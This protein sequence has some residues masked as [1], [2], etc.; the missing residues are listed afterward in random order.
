MSDGPRIPLEKAKAVAR[1]LAEKWSMTEET[2]CLVVGSVR[3]ERKDCGDLDF[4]APLPPDEDHDALYDAIGTSMGLFTNKK[5]LFG[6]SATPGCVK[7]TVVKGFN[8]MFKSLQLLITGA[9]GAQ[10]PV[11][12]ERYTPGPQG[13]RGWKE[14]MRTGPAEFGEALLTQ[15]KAICGTM[16][17]PTPG[18]QKGFWVDE[19]SLEIPTPTELHCFQR[20]RCLWLNPTTRHPDRLLCVDWLR[21]AAPTEV[22]LRGQKALN[23]L[24][25]GH[26]EEAWDEWR[27]QTV[28]LSTWKPT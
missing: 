14:I 20:A 9:S 17:T 7:G 13:N 16:G 4:I 12:I 10:I 27:M 3:R 18:S 5:G 26:A 15:W 22:L 25:L 2:G 19:N 8:P 24:G 11:Q 6:G 23:A 21:T 28:A 1:W